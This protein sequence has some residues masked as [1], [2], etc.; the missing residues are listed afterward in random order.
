MRFHSPTTQCRG[1]TCGEQI[2]F[3]KTR[4]G[5][6][7]PV[8]AESL[9]DED[10]AALSR[11]GGSVDYRSGEHIPHHSTCCDVESFRKR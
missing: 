3:V 9:S 8:N 6:S 1:N 5:K 4:A 11:V 10:I 7:M 2:G